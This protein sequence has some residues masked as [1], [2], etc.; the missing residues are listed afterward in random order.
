MSTWLQFRVRMSTLFS[1]H[2]RAFYV[3]WSVL[4][5]K[6]PKPYYTVIKH[7][8]HL[9]TRGTCVLNVQ[10]GLRPLHLLYDIEVINNK[11]AFSKPR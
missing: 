8:G 5:I 4:Q 7:D 9:R 1:K 10:A 3:D 6:K 11:Y 2:R